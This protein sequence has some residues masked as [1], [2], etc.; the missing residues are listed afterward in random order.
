MRRGAAVRSVDMSHAADRSRFPHPRRR[1]ASGVRA[2]RLDDFLLQL[3][4]ALADPVVQTVEALF[5]LHHRPLVD[6]LALLLQAVLEGLLVDGQLFAVFLVLA[7]NLE[8]LMQVFFRQATGI[9]EVLHF[10]LGC[11]Q[12]P[13]LG[14]RELAAPAFVG[15]VEDPLD[16]LLVSFAF[17]FFLL[18]LFDR[19]GDLGHLVAHHGGQN[20]EDGPIRD[21]HVEHDDV[22]GHRAPFEQRLHRPEVHLHDLEQVEDAVEEAREARLHAVVD[23]HVAGPAAV[24]GVEDSGDGL[25]EGRSVV[26]DV[27]VAHAACLFRINGIRLKEYPIWADQLHAEQGRNVQ[28]RDGQDH[29]PTHALHGLQHPNDQGVQGRDVLDKSKEPEDPQQP[30]HPE[31]PQHIAGAI[32]AGDVHA[33]VVVGGAE[34][35]QDPL[36]DHAAG[37]NAEIEHVPLQVD[38]IREELPAGVPDAHRDLERENEQERVLHPEQ[39]D[40]DEGILLRRVLLLKAH[41]DGVEA[42]DGHDESGERVGLHP[43]QVGLQNLPEQLQHSQVPEEAEKAE[44]LETPRM[45]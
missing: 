21:H 8:E 3:S 7:Q 10:L 26:A 23:I 41:D 24:R 29:H 39:G 25:V 37:H 15:P 6:G 40:R 2:Q 43:G 31:H 4:H 18:L 33:H 22:L 9:A 19:L 20:R 34:A 32:A 13:V 12:L 38:R 17:V 28:D 5:H 14:L 45:R 36:V 35:W 30:E 27:Q 16:E 42:D 11:E 1:R 44:I